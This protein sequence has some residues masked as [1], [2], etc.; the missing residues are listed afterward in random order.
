[1]KKFIVLL[2]LALVIVSCD[3]QA[4]KKPMPEAIWGLAQGSATVDTRSGMVTAGV[5]SNLEYW[6][7]D[8]T[9]IC[10]AVILSESPHE[11]FIISMTTVPY[12]QVKE[13]VLVHHFT[14]KYNTVDTGR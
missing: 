12:D 10:Y 9:Q 3:E 14:S 13:K 4:N 1:M 2:V 5:L 7:D 11:D 8:R 6:Y